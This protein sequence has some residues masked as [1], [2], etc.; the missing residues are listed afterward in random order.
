MSDPS[1]VIQKDDVQVRYNLIV[2]TSPIQIE[3]WEV[4]QLH[5]KE[6]ALVKISW[7]RP[8]GGNVTWELGS[9]MKDSYLNLFA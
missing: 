4:K 6:I 9:Q 7:G 3:D 8:T 2:G 5:G 1:H